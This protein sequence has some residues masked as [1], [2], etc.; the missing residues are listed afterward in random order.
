VQSTTRDAVLAATIAGALLAVLGVTE[1]LSTL[2]RPTVA[3]AGIATALGVEALFVADTPAAELWEHL[4]VQVGSAVAL[5]G[6]GGVALLVV[7]PTVVAAACWGLTTYFGL[8]AL[9]L[10]GVWG[11]EGSE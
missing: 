7:G 5:V 2:T 10:A 3:A 4:A 8:L 11:P 6:G 1:S 9:L